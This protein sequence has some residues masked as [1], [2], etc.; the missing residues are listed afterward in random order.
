ML[1]VLGEVVAIGRYSLHGNSLYI[2]DKDLIAGDDDDDDDLLP[3]LARLPAINPNLLDSGT[4]S[5]PGTA[6]SNTVKSQ[7]SKTRAQKR[8]PESAEVGKE[9]TKKAKVTGKGVINK[10][11]EGL[12]SISDALLATPSFEQSAV[13]DT[14]SSTLQGQAQQQV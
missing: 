1:K 11:S 5:R 2:S 9:I 4:T 12:I 8:H 3:P 14:V 13:K 7:T 6:D 10:I